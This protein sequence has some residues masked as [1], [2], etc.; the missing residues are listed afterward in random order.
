MYMN[1]D[2]YYPFYGDHIILD[3]LI[4]FDYIT[5]MLHIHIQPYTE[6][7]I[8]SESDNFGLR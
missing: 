1:F 3:E 5:L 2:H 8:I 7:N 6:W 4:L